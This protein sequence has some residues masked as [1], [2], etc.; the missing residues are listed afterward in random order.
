MPETLTFRGKFRHLFHDSLKLLDTVDVSLYHDVQL[1]PLLFTFED[2]L[3]I[4]S[5]LR[6]KESTVL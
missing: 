3:F 4:L 2:V 1:K 5:L 6:T